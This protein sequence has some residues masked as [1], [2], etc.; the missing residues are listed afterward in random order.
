MFVTVVWVRFDELLGY[1]H[2]LE[3]AAEEKKL[4]RKKL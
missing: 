2:D 3:L 4:Y 1:V